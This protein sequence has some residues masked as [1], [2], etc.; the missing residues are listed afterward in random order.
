MLD[1]AAVV[2]Q[3]DRT[4]LVAADQQL[5]AVVDDVARLMR[6]ARRPVDEMVDDHFVSLPVDRRV[7]LR[8]R[9]AEGERE[10]ADG[11]DDRAELH[12]ALRAKELVGEQTADQR[13]QVD[14]RRIAAV[15]A[16][17]LL[18]EKRKCLVR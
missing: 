18:S 3:R 16:G 14:Q 5:P 7:R 15:E 6:I 8:R 13:R 17:R 10:I 11:H 9:S 1:L 2:E 12:R 4:V